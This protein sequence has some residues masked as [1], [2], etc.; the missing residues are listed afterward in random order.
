VKPEGR[1]HLEN[2]SVDGKIM[3]LRETGW[4]VVD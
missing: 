3:D 4:E 1:D 2:P